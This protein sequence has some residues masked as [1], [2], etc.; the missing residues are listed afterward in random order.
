MDVSLAEPEGLVDDDELASPP[1]DFD[2]DGVLAFSDEALAFSDE[3]DDSLLSAFLRD[4][5]G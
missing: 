3:L 5:E 1:V 4:S 2:S